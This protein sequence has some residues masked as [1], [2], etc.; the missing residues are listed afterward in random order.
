[1]N[2]IRNNWQAFIL[3]VLLCAGLLGLGAILGY[4]ALRHKAFERTVMVKG[5]SEREYPA[6]VVIWPI[7]FI[8]AEN[9]LTEFY[10]TLDSRTTL[11][12]EFLLGAGLEATEL[13][14]GAPVVNDGYANQYGNGE[15]PLFRY[16][17]SRTV[18]VYTDKVGT[19][20]EAMARLG[21]LG[22]DGLVLSGD[23]WRNSTQYLFT[24]LNDVKPEMVEE[25]T[26]NAREVAEKFAADSQSRLGKIKQASQG[27]FSISDRDANN[28]HIKTVRVVSTLEYY[29]AD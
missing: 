6:D 4:S 27:Q 8:A 10:E 15:R 20:R 9:D 7:E 29:L 3:G 19:V 13:S 21:E 26:R 11:V 24:T 14:Y 22:R 2:T 23:S 17:G 28:P 1:M 12:R 5:L 18:T 16:T 25:A